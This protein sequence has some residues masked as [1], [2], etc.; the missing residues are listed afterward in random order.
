MSAFFALWFASGAVMLVVPFP[1]LS[2]TDRLRM[3]SQV[4]AS[5]A[6]VSPSE[7]ITEARRARPAAEVT[8]LRL[9]DPGTGTAQYVVGLTTGASAELVA[10]DAMSGRRLPPVGLHEAERIARSAAEAL[11][12]PPA[13]LEMVGPFHYDQWVVHQ[14]FDPFRPFYRAEFRDVGGFTLYVS[15]TTGEVRQKTTARERFW[16]YP[17]AITHWIYPTFIRRSWALW[18]QLVWWLSLA[19]ILVAILGLW[20]GL[21]RMRN[22]ADLRGAARISPFRGW[23]R[24]HHVLG[25]TGGLVLLT[26]IFSG[27]LSMDHGRLFATLSPGAE[28]LERYYGTSLQ[29][30]AESLGRASLPDVGRA[31]ELELLRFDGRPLLLSREPGNRAA[32]AVDDRGRAFSYEPSGSSIRAA[33]RRGWRNH[34][35]S[36]GRRLADDDLYGRLLEGPLPPTAVRFRVADPARSW[37]HVDGE[38]GQVLEVMNRSRRTYRWLYNGLHSFD[39]PYLA[40][41]PQLRLAVLVPL[42]LL[43]AALSVT[44]VVVGVRRLV[45]RR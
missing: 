14:R 22:R 35:V 16:N 7:A 9:L 32:W 33:L 3:L 24:W 6:H 11:G 8:S 36:D 4:R 39:L 37:V 34:E 42:L 25:L 17:G 21:T 45:G 2:E 40:Q 38:T 43:G 44:S 18:D 1:S 20:I 13:A 23:L 5:D 29:G 10:V 27:W 26:W 28:R 31:S 41:R 12:K 19:G 30:A 15:A